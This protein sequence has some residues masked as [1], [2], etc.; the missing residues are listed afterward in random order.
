MLHKSK[1]SLDPQCLGHYT[2]LFIDKVISNILEKIFVALPVFTLIFLEPTKIKNK[3]CLEL[4]FC[5]TP[6]V[7]HIF[8]W[9]LLK[10]FTFFRA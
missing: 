3:F 9:D 6:I 5:S 7:D 10:M 4:F 8:L 2:H 1:S